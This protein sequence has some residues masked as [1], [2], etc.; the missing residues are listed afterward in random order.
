MKQWGQKKAG[1][2]SYKK[3]RLTSNN[4]RYGPTN[5]DNRMSE[6][7]RNMLQSYK[8]YD[9]NDEK[10]K[11][12][13]NSWRTYSSNGEIQ[14]DIFLRGSISPLLFLIAMMQLSY[15]ARECTGATNLQHHKKRII[16]GKLETLTEKKQNKKETKL[17]SQDK[18][19][20]ICIEKC[21]TLRK[22]WENRN[23]RSYWTTKSR[24]HL[25]RTTKLLESAAEI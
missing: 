23:T 14:C 20:K 12:E 18:G 21:T 3:S 5:F 2:C 8:P 13:I 7:I 6:N 9:K 24:K 10:L 17:W 4:Q 22:M 19:I 11:K 15:T 1:K 16:P 25:E